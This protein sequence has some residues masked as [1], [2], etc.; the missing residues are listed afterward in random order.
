MEAIQLGPLLIKKS[1]IVLLFSCLLAYL[2]ISMYLR[3]KPDILKTVENHLTSGMLLWIV[4]FK[5]SIIIFR[6]S[7]IWTNPYGLLF[8]TGGTN[9]VYLATV[10]TTLFLYWKF[11][12][13]DIHI[14]YSTIIIVPSILIVVTG[15]FG[16]LAIL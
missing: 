7:I 12:Q 11:H 3:S 15:Y 2:Y 10:G 5:F 6:P 4:V 16:I 14:K 9:G 13:S 8:F 1:Y